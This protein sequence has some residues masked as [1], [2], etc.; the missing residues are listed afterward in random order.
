MPD[1]EFVLQQDG[2]PRFA[3][4]VDEQSNAVV[5]RLDDAGGGWNRLPDTGVRRYHPFQFSSDGRD[6]VARYSEKGEPDRLV[7]ENLATGQRTVLF[8]DPV[9]DVSGVMVGTS[10]M[11]FAARSAVGLP[12][13]RYF[14]ETGADAVLHK[15]LAA[16]FPGQHLAFIDVS[17]DKNLFLFS[18]RS[19]RDP[20]SYYLFDRTTMKADMLFSAMVDRSRADGR[21]PSDQFQGARRARAARLP[22]HARACK[23]RK[24]AAGAAAARRPARHLRQL[25]LRR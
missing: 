20:G 16:Q 3:S 13:V 9:G 22:H 4:G 5:F 25:V 18:V 6:F 2:T 23:G 15:Q 21:T 12:Q 14:D 19:D 7:R 10:A 11:P 17:D 1:L 24:A 8:G